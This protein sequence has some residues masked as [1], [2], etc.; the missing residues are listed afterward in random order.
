MF[1]MWPAHASFS[2]TTEKYKFK[3]KQTWTIFEVD[4]SDHLIKSCFFSLPQVSFRQIV[5]CLVLI[6]SPPHICYPLTTETLFSL[7]LSLS[8]WYAQVGSSRFRI[9]VR[10]NIQCNS[11]FYLWKF[12]NGWRIVIYTFQL[13]CNHSYET[14]DLSM[15][16]S[17]SVHT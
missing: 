6:L 10:N 1:R 16:G 12:G 9:D 15:P 7:S 5:T 4:R 11:R 2:R 3:Y 8:S 17:L 13:F 14:L